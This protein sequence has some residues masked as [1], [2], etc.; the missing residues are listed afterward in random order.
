MCT[1]PRSR[2]VL[3]IDRAKCY[4]SEMIS[5][6]QLDFFGATFGVG[7]RLMA[8]AASEPEDDELP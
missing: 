1:Q 3:Y 7:A 5:F 4:T 8:P 6:L 2:H